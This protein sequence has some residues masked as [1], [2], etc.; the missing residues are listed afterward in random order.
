MN[1]NEILVDNLNASIEA[2]KIFIEDKLQGKIFEDATS[3][4]IKR[5]K[6][7]GRLYIAESQKCSE[8]LQRPPLPVSPS[9]F[10]HEHGPRV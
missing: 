9:C 5:Y 3:E 2:K 8:S 6:L 4:V 10:S 1:I 7:G